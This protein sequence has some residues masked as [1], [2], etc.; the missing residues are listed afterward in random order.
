MRN[1]NFLPI[2]ATKLHLNKPFDMAYKKLVTH[3]K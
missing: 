1:K 2:F 3:A